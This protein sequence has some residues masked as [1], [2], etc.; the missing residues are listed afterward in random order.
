MP[1]LPLAI[2]VF[3][4]WIDRL[5][6]AGL[7]VRA[8]VASLWAIAA[9]LVYICL[10]RLYRALFFRIRNARALVIRNKWPQIV[11]GVVP[12]RTWLF[13]YL[14]RKIV[15]QI[16]LDTLDATSDDQAAPLISCLRSSGLLEMRIHESRTR[17]GW[18]RREALTTLGRTRAPEA[19]AALAEA[20]RDPNA[21]NRL[22]A[23]RGLGQIGLPEAVDYL[24]TG[25]VEPDGTLTVP[26]I[27]LQNALLRCSRSK[28]SVL[29]PP[30]RRAQ[31]KPREILA[32]VVSELATPEIGD[33]LLMLAC[34][35]LPEVRASAARALASADPASAF[36]VLSVLSADP[37]W[38]VRLRAVAALSAIQDSRAI[39]A[40]VR[41]LCDRNRSIRVRAAAAL[42]KFEAELDYILHNVIA[43]QDQYALQAMISELERSDIYEKLLVEL[44]H[45]TTA[46]RANEML[47]EALR[48]GAEKLKKNLRWQK[49]EE[50]VSQ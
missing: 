23:V 27:P 48:T 44:R 13:K 37:E 15:E 31:G 6:P 28:L 17:K 33:D 42:V 25:A 35:P 10:R 46:H 40:L 21:E 19:I 41:C 32:R 43:T 4:R 7:V 39:P 9:L 16:L 26:E 18:E 1:A 50:V 36:P 3:F 20:L 34:D 38:E 11:S 30:L 49:L 14:D 29:L 5:G 47:V 12:P 24:L 22:A 8:I 45:S 2:E